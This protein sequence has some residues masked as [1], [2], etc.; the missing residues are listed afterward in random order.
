MDTNKIDWSPI[1][2]ANTSRYEKFLFLI[3]HLTG[4]L[5]IVP[6]LAMAAGKSYGLWMLL[7]FAIAFILAYVLFK[8]SHR[9]RTGAEVSMGFRP[10]FQWAGNKYRLKGDK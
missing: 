2:P 7:G 9:R 5:W 4:G 8:I 3:L 10:S 6:I 1:F